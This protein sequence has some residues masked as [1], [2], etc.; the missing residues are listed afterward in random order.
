MISF[1]S[2]PVLAAKKAVRAPT[3]VITTRVVGAYSNKGDD[4]NNR[5]T[6][7]VTS[8]HHKYNWLYLWL[9]ISCPV[10]RFVLLFC[11]RALRVVDEDI[12]LL[13]GPT[14]QYCEF[15]ILWSF[16]FHFLGLL[17]LLFFFSCFAYAFSVLV[18]P[19]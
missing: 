8:V 12:I 6:P 2:S 13:V 15:D 14:R 9:T 11:R 16:F 7:A 3:H 1:C 4:R 19:P 18:S 17:L 5:Y 10:N